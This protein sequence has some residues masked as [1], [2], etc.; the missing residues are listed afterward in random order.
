M[1]SC[2]YL[3]EKKQNACFAQ[4]KANLL[5]LQIGTSMPAL[6]SSAERAHLDVVLQIPGR[7]RARRAGDGDVVFSAEAAFDPVRPFAEHALDYLVLP[8]NQPVAELVVE[9]C[10]GDEES[11]P[12]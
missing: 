6:T 12:S 9:V 10:L 1:N 8:I 4:R 2:S 5:R 3:L 11:D 7:G